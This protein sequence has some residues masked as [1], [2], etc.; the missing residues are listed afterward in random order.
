MGIEKF[1]FSRWVRERFEKYDL[2]S[3][4]TAVHKPW[5]VRRELNSLGVN[6]NKLYYRY[7]DDSDALD[8]MAADWDTLVILDATRYDVF[9]QTNWLDGDLHRVRS[10]ASHSIEFVHRN[11]EGRELHDTVY[12]TANPYVRE[13]SEGTFHSVNSLLE[14]YDTFRAIR[15]DKMTEEAIAA[16]EEFPNKRLV[17]HYMQPH[18]PFIGEYGQY[19]QSEYLGGKEV[20]GARWMEEVVWDPNHPLDVEMVK[21]AYRE[22]LEIALDEAERLASNLDGKT[23]IT[24][25][26]GELFGE[27]TRPIPARL[28]GHEPF[29]HYGN[30]VS[31]PWFELPTDERREI[32]ADPPEERDRTTEVTDDQLAALGYL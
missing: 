19:L 18:A 7:V 5:A 31:V 26:H 32:R 1:T 3:L 6:L 15:P 20:A 25:D 21:K 30:L 23:V 10:G 16:H 24:A 2:G 27:R 22:N 8:V 29:V 17:V 4:K 12:V 9:T 14:A 13:L 11:F 28:Y